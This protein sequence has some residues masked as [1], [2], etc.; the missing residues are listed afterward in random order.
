MQQV[1]AGDIDIEAAFSTFDM[2]LHGAMMFEVDQHQG[3]AGLRIDFA[4]DIGNQPFR[5]PWR[6]R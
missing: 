5:R 4:A 6:G 1:A 3:I 2:I